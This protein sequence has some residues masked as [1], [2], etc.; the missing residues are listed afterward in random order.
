MIDLILLFIWST[1]LLTAVFALFL[2]DRP[3][4]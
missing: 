3:T 2:E 1:V 4:R